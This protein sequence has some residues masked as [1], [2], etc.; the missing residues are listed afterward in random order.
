MNPHT[1]DI[2]QASWG[3]LSPEA[4]LVKQSTVRDVHRV[5]L[6]QVDVYVKRDRPRG[7]F[8]LLLGGL[9]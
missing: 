8:E 2:L 9:V 7:A 5:K 1:A 3:R 4:V 6:G